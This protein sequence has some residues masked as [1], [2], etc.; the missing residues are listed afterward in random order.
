MSILHLVRHGQ[1]N[2]F[3]EDRDRLSVPGR[4][5]AVL[6]G[7]YW[8]A[9]GVAPHAVHCGTLRR[10]RETA[11]LLGFAPPAADPAFNEYDTEGLLAEAPRLASADPVFREQWDAFN[12]R[13]GDPDAN[14]FFQK[15]F[16]T[17]MKR[18]VQG[19]PGPEPWAE[20]RARVETGLRNLMAQ[21]PAGS[22]LVVATSGG[23]VGVA[24][25]TVLGAPAEA[26][27]ALHWRV[28]NASVTSFVFSGGRVSLDQF[29]ATP[30]LEEELVTYR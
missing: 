20:F 10:Q 21:A 22:V 19:M 8:R 4:R 16:E 25:Q 15:M 2:P 11:E 12:H 9:R 6:L 17:L 26:A 14:R 7:E 27:V 30:H 24:V 1:A 5:Q 18:F 28:R 3:G 29:N 13:R 23:P